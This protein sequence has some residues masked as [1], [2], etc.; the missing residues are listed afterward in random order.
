VNASRYE[1]SLQEIVDAV[2]P[3]KLA[4]DGGPPLMRDAAAYLAS[5]V[6]GEL[7]DLA[8]IR[9]RVVELAASA[10]RV[11][12]AIGESGE[13]PTGFANSTP[14]RLAAMI[15]G[16][17]P[18]TAGAWIGSDDR[19]G[20]FADEMI[21]AAEGYANADPRTVSGSEP[22]RMG[23][24]FRVVGLAGHGLASMP[25]LQSASET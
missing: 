3:H 9:E 16:N 1:A 6:E 5:A 11:I 24:L 14:D 19:V 13:A 17:A 10:L 20:R 12:R 7:R 15:D 21:L 8:T 25:E 22:N 2:L 18:N 4:L 23:G